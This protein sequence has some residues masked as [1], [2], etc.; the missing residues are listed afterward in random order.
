M[1]A[2][3]TNH[4]AIE[5]RNSE[6]AARLYSDTEYILALT[7]RHAL[8]ILFSHILHIL[9]C[10]DYYLSTSLRP[11]LQWNQK[12]KQE[13]SLEK[14]FGTQR[15]YLLFHFLLYSDCSSSVVKC[16][17]SGDILFFSILLLA[18]INLT[19]KR[20]EANL[21]KAKIILS[22]WLRVIFSFRVIWISN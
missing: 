7:T 8:N 22:S 17:S 4:S 2:E 11:I 1:M 6:I 9:A 18:L 3:Y 15:R 5:R 19:K 13:S 14:V 21:I 12:E 10:A 20:H 16:L